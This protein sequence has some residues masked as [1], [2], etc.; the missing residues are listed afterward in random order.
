MNDVHRPQARTIFFF[1]R[2]SERANS[3]QPNIESIKCVKIN[4]G[5]NMWN[6]K[7]LNKK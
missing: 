4:V 1:H 3:V 5:R 7:G 6:R 2:N